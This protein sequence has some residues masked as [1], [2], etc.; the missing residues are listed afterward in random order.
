MKVHR[1]IARALGDLG[2]H[3]VFG[4]MGDLNVLYLADYE[5]IEPSRFVNALFEGAAVSMADGF[6]RATGSIGCASVTHGPALTNT[7][8]ALV[9]AV[10]ARTPVILLS[11]D[12]PSH[13]IDHPQIVSLE[14]FADVAGAGYV[15]CRRPDEVGQDLARAARKAV[16]ERRPVL[17]NIPADLMAQDAESLSLLP[18]DTGVRRIAPHPES[19]AIDAALGTLVSARRPLVLAGQGALRSDCGD[20]LRRLAELIGAHLGTTL[21]AREMFRGEE[22]NIGVVGGMG[23]RQSA[24]VVTRSDCVL[25]FGAS[26]NKYTASDGAL[27][28]H[29][30]IIQCDD[31]ARA[32]TGM[33]DIE[34]LGDAKSIAALLIEQLEH[35]GL[36]PRSMEPLGGNRR[37]DSFADS[38][39][40]GMLDMRT[41][42]VE[43]DQMLDRDRCVVTDAGRFQRAPWRY[44]GTDGPRRFTHTMNFSS[45]GL[46]L[47]TGMGYAFADQNRLCVVVAGDGG[48]MMA[49]NEFQ[50]AVKHGLKLLYVILNDQAFGV[51]Y[52]KLM[53]DGYDPEFSRL[54]LA[55]FAEVARGFGGYGVTA[56]SIGDLKMAV[57]QVRAGR[58]PLVIDVRCDPAVQLD[59]EG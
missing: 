38:S 42:M 3:R 13:V 9:E 18:V 12:T 54:N 52:H 5:A 47:A 19:A 17:V 33:A 2:I 6:A 31:D 51:E 28:R 35:A 34:V 14:S 27:F 58:L 16:A 55:D 15:R 10:R 30:R 11:G 46:G 39:R 59:D 44:L 41:A 40:D 8:T 50:T 23:D 45:I 29:R 24:Q 4:L 37:Y 56:S 20:E 21:L 57:D 43:L 26:L 48:G 36:E 32:F 53:E 49:I 7:L 25:A 22:N 1:I